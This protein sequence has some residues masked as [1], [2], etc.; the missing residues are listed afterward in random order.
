MSN[1]VRDMAERSIGKYV[2]FFQQFKKVDKDYPSPEEVIQRQYDPDSPFELTFLTLKLVKDHNGISFDVD[3]MQVVRD[4]QKIVEQMIE[5]VNSIPRPDLGFRNPEQTSLWDIIPE[6][7]LV[8]N[9]LTE[10]KEILME[11]LGVT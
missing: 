4:L 10:I 6:D 5:K 8:Q 2:E 7:E 11:H 1:Q 3:I 9:A